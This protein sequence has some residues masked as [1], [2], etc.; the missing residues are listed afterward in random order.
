M[1]TSL[2]NDDFSICRAKKLKLFVFLVAISPTRSMH[3]DFAC[4]STWLGF[5]NIS[6][7]ANVHAKN[8]T[9][10]SIQAMANNQFKGFIFFTTSHLYNLRICLLYL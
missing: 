2:V 1:N 5:L 4:D 8:F 9:L 3:P 7:E 10:F 6:V